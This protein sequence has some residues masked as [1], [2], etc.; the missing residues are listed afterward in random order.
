MM[1]LRLYIKPYRTFR[2]PEILRIPFST[3]ILWV[4]RN[5]PFV[6]SFDNLNEY[7]R[8]LK[9]RIEINLHNDFSEFLYNSNQVQ[10]NTFATYWYFKDVHIF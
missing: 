7:Q 9:R 3:V 6:A 5:M 4:S 10:T 8:V 2:A 1:K